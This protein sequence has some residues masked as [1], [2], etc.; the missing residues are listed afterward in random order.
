MGEGRGYPHYAGVKETPELREGTP[1]PEPSEED[2][3]VVGGMRG[4]V[5]FLVGLTGSRCGD[6]GGCRGVGEVGLDL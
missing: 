5:G 1:G 3:V 2:G 6:S 4:G